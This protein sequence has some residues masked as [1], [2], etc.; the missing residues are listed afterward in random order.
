MKTPVWVLEETILA[1]HEQLLG[2][3]GGSSG[4][5]DRALPESALARPVNLFA[6][7]APNVFDLAAS[8]GF[9]L[10]KSHAFVDGNKRTGFTVAVSF[11]ELNG[12]RFEATEADATVCTLA[13]AAD[14]MS[15]AEYS[16]WLAA[17]A[18]RVRSRT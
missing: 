12:Y 8:Y 17:N 16:A 18:R 3:F 7:G 14:E 15:E 4:I 2:V 10:V 13:L 9:G 6:Y 5:R 11:L 1:L